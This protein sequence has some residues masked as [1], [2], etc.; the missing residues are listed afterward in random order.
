MSPSDPA[1]IPSEPRPLLQRVLIVEDHPDS[2]EALA[3]L[4][5]GLGAE[6]RIAF[7]GSK[8]LELALELV[9]QLVLLDLVIPGVD[10]YRVA[11]GIRE[12]PALRDAALVAITGLKG[13]EVS[14]AAK[15]AGF[16]HL[17]RKPVDFL[18]LKQWIAQRF[19]FAGE[20]TGTTA[21]RTTGSYR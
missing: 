11:Q 8:A 10:G 14:E 9:P 16:D 3:M 17:L 6:A 20:P 19:Q 13:E 15:A 2:A 1:A 7:D 5:S 12:H 18:E 4:V 21:R